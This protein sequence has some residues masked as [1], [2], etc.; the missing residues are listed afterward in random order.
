MQICNY[1]VGEKPSIPLKKL[2]IVFS[3]VLY[4]PYFIISDENQLLK[5]LFSFGVKS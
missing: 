5:H 4:K 3:L 1:L 2:T